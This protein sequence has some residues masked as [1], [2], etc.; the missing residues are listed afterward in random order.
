M[1]ITRGYGTRA[2]IT[3]GYGLGFAVL[4]EVIKAF[5]T[6]VPKRLLN[7]LVGINTLTSSVAKR[8]FNSSVDANKSSMVK[9]RK[10]DGGVDVR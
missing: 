4:T 2:I 7:S 1:I 6:V 9:K 8:F 10:F 3:Q 5:E